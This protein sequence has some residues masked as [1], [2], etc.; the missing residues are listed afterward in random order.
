MKSIIKLKKIKIDQMG[1]HLLVKA[2]LNGKSV[3]LVLDTGASQTVFDYHIAKSNSD[4]KAEQ[5]HDASSTGVGGEQLQSHIIQVEKFKIGDLL[6]RDNHFVLLDLQHVNAQY[7]KIGKP[8]IHGVL[9]GDVLNAFN[10]VI[11]YKKGI[12]V[13]SYKK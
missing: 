6:I 12:M 11:D 9:G 8:P 1:F 10:A 4:N 3:T 5:L 13:L 7:E 2:K